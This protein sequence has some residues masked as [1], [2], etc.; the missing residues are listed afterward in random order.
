M[1]ILSNWLKEKLRRAEHEAQVQEVA[2]LAALLKEQTGR[3]MNAAAKKETKKPRA[4]PRPR[5]TDVTGTVE[6]FINS[7]MEEI[8]GVGEEFREIYDNASE[9]LQASQVNQS[10]DG[11][12]SEIENLDEPSVE[13]NVLGSLDCSYRHD[14]GPGRSESRQTRASNGAGKLRAAAEAIS[15]WLDENEEIPE[16]D[17]NDPESMRIRAEKLEEL[18]TRNIDPDDYEKARTE[19]GELV[20][21]LEDIAD[22]VEGLEYPGMF[23]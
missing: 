6:D 2:R 22:T 7:G 21:T 18:E 16:A 9:N 11:T 14:R 10:R 1:I 20:G 19:A 23:G 4:A 8:K 5:Y 15:G 12:A 17:Q 13:S 3:T